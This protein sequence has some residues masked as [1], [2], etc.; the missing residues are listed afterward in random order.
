[1]TPTGLPVQWIMSPEV[2]Q[3]SLAQLTLVKSFRERARQPNPEPSMTA[4][5]TTAESSAETGDGIP[6]TIAN[7]ARQPV[8]MRDFIAETL[9]NPKPIGYSEAIHPAFLRRIRMQVDQSHQP[10]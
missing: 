1:V 3:V 6:V 7:N 2:V 4:R 10:H 9:T 8:N 5:V